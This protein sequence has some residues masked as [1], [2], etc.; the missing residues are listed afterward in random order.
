MASHWRAPTP[1]GSFGDRPPV[2]R[3]PAHPLLA[4]SMTISC[5]QCP[6]R[7]IACADCMVTALLAW[8][9]Q[10]PGDHELHA[11]DAEVGGPALDA[12]EE[13]A[14]QGFL[15]AG[16]ISAVEAAGARAVRTGHSTSLRRA[17]G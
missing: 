8:P 2:R 12:D 4:P 1:E 6:V 16:L 5:Q 9:V 13:R 11:P 7:E 14:V 15:H 10:H 17:V 3:R